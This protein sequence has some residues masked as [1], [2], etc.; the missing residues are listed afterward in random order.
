M[1][2]QIVGDELVESLQR[3]VG[4]VEEDG[5]VAL[6]GAAADQLQR[7][8]GGA[9]AAAAAGSATKGWLRTSASGSSVSSGIRR[10]MNSGS[11]MD[12]MMSVS[13]MAGAA[14]STADSGLSYLRAVHDVGPVNQLGD[15][16][17]VKAERVE[18]MWAR[19]LVQEVYVG[20]KNLRAP[21]TGSCW[22]ARKCWWSS[23]V[24]KADWW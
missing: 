18:A 16:R 1:G 22:Q 12:S 13:F 21:H 3:M 11:W 23:G 14:I 6:L 4:D 17:G 24:R 8:P 10:G 15:R 2:I 19:K 7:M 9:P 5:A 20:S